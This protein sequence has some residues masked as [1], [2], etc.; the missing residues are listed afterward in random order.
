MSTILKHLKK[1]ENNSLNENYNPTIEFS[2]TRLEKNESYNFFV[3]QAGETK[4]YQRKLSFE[5][6]YKSKVSDLNFYIAY[7]CLQEGDNCIIREEDKNEIN[8]ITIIFAHIG[9]KID[10]QNEINP[11]KKDL[12]A[13]EYQLS[14]DDDSYMLYFTRWKTIKYS[15]ENF[16]FG[17]LFGN[18]KEYYGGELLTTNFYKQNTIDDFKEYENLCK[19]LLGEV[20]INILDYNQD[21]DYYNRRKNLYLLQLLIF[22]LYQWVYII[23]LH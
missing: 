3:I 4:E 6:L 8:L 19:K 5:V 2:F 20:M 10:H 13:K 14:L 17:N 22:F 18:T 12:I 21:F 7:S 16:I 11:I 15:E 9:Y 23:C 1:L